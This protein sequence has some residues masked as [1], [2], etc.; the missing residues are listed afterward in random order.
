MPDLE[1]AIEQTVGK[2]DP[3]S[4]WA[5]TKLNYLQLPDWIQLWEFFKFTG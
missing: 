3:F 2:L 1:L 5:M 4:P